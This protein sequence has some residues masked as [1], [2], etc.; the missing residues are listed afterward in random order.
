MA[1]MNPYISQ[2]GF[3]DAVRSL[4]S[5]E[6]WIRLGSGSNHG[7][8]LSLNCTILV[9]AILPDAGKSTSV[10]LPSQA[11]APIDAEHVFIRIPEGPTVRPWAFYYIK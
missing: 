10:T 2:S 1:A 6:P 9:E 7:S 5:P 3:A 4:P 11:F 8:E